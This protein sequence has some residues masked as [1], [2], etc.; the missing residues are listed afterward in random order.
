MVFIKHHPKEV[1]DIKIS[2]TVTDIA[3]LTGLSVAR[4]RA[5]APKVPN[6]EKTSAGWIFD[7]T[8][9]EYF[10]KERPNG[11]PPKKVCNLCFKMLDRQEIHTRIGNVH[12]HCARIPVRWIWIIGDKVDALTCDPNKILMS[13]RANARITAIAYE[14]TTEKILSI[15]PKSTKVV[16]PEFNV[17]SGKESCTP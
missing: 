11:R 9:V 7:P 6:A 13:M 2:Y 17:F 15:V 4:V 14:M 5:L 8:G 16:K 12:E 10:M 1:P 3:E